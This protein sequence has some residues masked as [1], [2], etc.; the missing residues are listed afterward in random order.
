[1]TYALFFTSVASRHSLSDQSF[2]CFLLAFP[3]VSS[4]L[5]WTAPEIHDETQS[6][7]IQL[8]FSSV[9][10]STIDVFSSRFTPSGS[11][12]GNAKLKKYAI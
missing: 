11:F 9:S 7:S 2:G 4:A 6:Q 10:D 5:L 12:E 8:Q 3:N 1:L